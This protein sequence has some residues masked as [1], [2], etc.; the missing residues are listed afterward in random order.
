M[1]STMLKERNNQLTRIQ[2]KEL[3][4]KQLQGMLEKK[5]DVAMEVVDFYREVLSYSCL[6]VY[7]SIYAY[8]A[9]LNYK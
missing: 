8:D 6:C 1:L 9:C 7:L 2:A 3:E 4:S 5:V